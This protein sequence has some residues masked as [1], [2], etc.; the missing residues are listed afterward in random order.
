MAL[1]RIKRPESL[2]EYSPQEL[3]RV[4]G[5]DRAP[6][7]KTLRRKLPRLAAVGRAAQFGQAL[8]QL[9]FRPEPP[10]STRLLQQQTLFVTYKLYFSLTDFIL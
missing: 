5:L 6:E 4:P 7:V 10:H 1:W 9:L 8:A 3:G 2:K